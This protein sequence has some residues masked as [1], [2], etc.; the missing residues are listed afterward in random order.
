MAKRKIVILKYMPEIGMYE[1]QVSLYVA[2]HKGLPEIEKN[3][4]NAIVK[5]KREQSGM[6]GYTVMQG[7]N[8]LVGFTNDI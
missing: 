1:E 3:A 8:V 4:R 5:M 2:S 7:D 6:Y